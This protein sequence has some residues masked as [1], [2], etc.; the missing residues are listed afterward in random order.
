MEEIEFKTLVTKL[1]PKI[2]TNANKSYTIIY[3]LAKTNL[4]SIAELAKLLQLNKST[5]IRIYHFV[6][7]DLFK[8]CQPIRDAVN[9]KKVTKEIKLKIKQI[10]DDKKDT[11][12]QV[13]LCNLLNVSKYQIDKLKSDQHV[14]D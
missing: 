10:I 13:D 12:N 6:E 1:K 7:S 4:V 11:L 8:S 14:V 9:A 2:H 5:I 3:S